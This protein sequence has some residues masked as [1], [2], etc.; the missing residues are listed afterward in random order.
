MRTGMMQQLQLVEVYM[1]HVMEH[2]SAPTT[3][4]INNTGMN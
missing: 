3:P 4:A 1:L 2:E